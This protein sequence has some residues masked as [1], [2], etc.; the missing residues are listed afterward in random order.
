MLRI[1]DSA[2]AAHKTHADRLKAQPAADN[3]ILIAGPIDD[4]A[5]KGWYFE[6]EVV[7]FPSDVEA[8]LSAMSGPLT[9]RV[10][11]PGGDVFA[12]VQIANALTRYEGE[13]LVR[14]EGLAASAA[15]FV[16]MR[17]DTIEMDEMAQVMIHRPTTSLWGGDEDDFRA[18]AERLRVTGDSMIQSYTKRNRAGLKSDEIREMVKAETWMDAEMA[19]AKGF[20]DRIM[21]AVASDP[22]PDAEAEMEARAKVHSEVQRAIFADLLDSP[23]LSK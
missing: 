21:E 11:S 23:T 14:I 1:R 4:D 3:E 12:G 18:D 15:S 7:V 17:G 8:R 13:V 16:A 5:Y 22:E 2:I 6:D 20:A 9:V 10:N 19:I